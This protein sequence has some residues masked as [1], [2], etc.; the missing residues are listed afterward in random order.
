MPTVMGEW[1]TGDLFAGEAEHTVTH[2]TWGEEG[3][4]RACS[5]VFCFAGLQRLGQVEAVPFRVRKIAWRGRVHAL[6]WSS[7]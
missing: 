3:F 4:V 2:M 1:S 7:R 5:M 6:E